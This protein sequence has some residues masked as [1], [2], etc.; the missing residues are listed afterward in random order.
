MPSGLDCLIYST[1]LLAYI[2]TF[3]L[4]MVSSEAWLFMDLDLLKYYFWLRFSPVVC[5]FLEVYL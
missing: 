5:R 4:G 1:I 2:S 3:L